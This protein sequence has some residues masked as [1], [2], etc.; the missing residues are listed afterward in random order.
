MTYKEGGVTAPLGFKAAGVHCGIRRNTS[1]YDL[2]LILS[3]VSCAA[4]AVYTTNLVQAAPIQITKRNI[5]NGTARAI[6]INSG[7]ANACAPNGEEN[8][9]RSC[10]ALADA[11]GIGVTDIIVN[12]T[13]VIGQQL[14]VEAIENAMPQLVSKLKRYEAA[15]SANELIYGSDDAALAIMTTDTFPKQCAVT[16]TIDGKEVT[17]GAIAK[18][19]GMIHPNMATLLCLITTDCNISN[20]LL[21]KALRDAVNDSFNRVS[22]DGDT[23]TNDMTAVMA[24]GLAG[25]ALISEENGDYAL[26]A[27]AL[28]EVCL[29][30]AKMIA[31]DGEGARK[32]LTCRVT[33]ASSVDD[34]KKLSMSVNKSS[35]VK[36]AMTG[37]DANVGRVMCALGYA[38]VAFDPAKVDVTF[39]SSGGSIKVC[40]NG[41][42][43]AFDEAKAKEILLKDDILILCEMKSGGYAAEAYGCDLT[44]DYVKIN[45]DYRS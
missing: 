24:S 30:L 41:L 19:S 44:S 23:S 15:A 35:L 37:A 11:A 31:R 32:L 14:P 28:N 2:A 21:K 27:K 4:A 5:E 33:G 13:G 10:K 8:A 25:N 34:A 43:L 29:K 22:V 40:E 38:G 20:A 45:G 39:A 3:D 1:K 7:N 26:F 9:L 17:V 6:L 42:G 18:G 16:V 36:T 12:S